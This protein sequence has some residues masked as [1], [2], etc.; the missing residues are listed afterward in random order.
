MKS[1]NRVFRRADSKIEFDLIAKFISITALVLT[2]LF[3]MAGK[4]YHDGYLA[5]FKLETSMFP[6]DTYTTFSTATIALIYA[7]VE[8]L[9]GTQAIF[10]AHYGV[11]I[12]IYA[13]AV[14]GLFMFRHLGRRASREHKTSPPSKS[15]SYST[16][17]IIKEIGECALWILM[18]GYM[19]YLTMVVVAAFLLLLIGPFNHI[20]K[21]QAQKNLFSEFKNSPVVN[22][23]SRNGIR[24]NYRVIECSTLFCALYARDVVITV[25]VSEMKWVVSDVREK[26]KLARC[27][28]SADTEQA[29]VTS[30][31]YATRAVPI[32]VKPSADNAFRF[33]LKTRLGNHCSTLWRQAQAPYKP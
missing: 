23:T 17:F 7:I 14:A 3:Y 24:E 32:L 8:I 27:W 22:I 2:P 21:L 1:N 4:A 25:P 19:T 11:I 16:A 18:P 33:N 15:I 9:T 29:W 6:L 5:F 28:K 10:S 12:S 31:L 20:G 26:G 13:L 30:A